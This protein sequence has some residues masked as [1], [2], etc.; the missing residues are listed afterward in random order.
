MN[1][2]TISDAVA[3][4]EGRIAKAVLGGRCDRELIE[5][6]YL[7]VA[8]PA[9]DRGGTGEGTEVPARRAGP[10]GARAGSAVG[11]AQQQSIFVQL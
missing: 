10:R 2:K 5:E 4:A 3:D 6:L 9:A 7:G 1:G 8:E 11:A